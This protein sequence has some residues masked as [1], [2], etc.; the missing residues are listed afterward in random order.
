MTKYIAYYRV[1]T[2]KQGE[3][4][5]GLAAQR[6]AV[7]RYVSVACGEIIREFTEIESGKRSDRPKLAEALALTKRSGG[8]LVVAK[9][10]RLARNVNFL[11]SL[12]NAGV[13]FVCCDNPTANKL[14][15]QILA[16]MAEHEREM[17]SKRTKEGLAAAK[18]R[19]VILGS[20]REGHWDGLEDRRR[21]G[22]AKGGLEAGKRHK[23]DAAHAY[24][25]ILPVMAQ[26]R[27]CG[28]TLQGIA[29]HLNGEGYKTRRN[30]DWS[31]STVRNVL[32]Q[33]EVKA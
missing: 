13:D 15:I 33:C 3:S 23:A 7:E 8:V 14:T 11:T 6:E 19:G 16:V 18:A 25:D 30:R 24:D 32:K 28:E 10:D 4:G 2:R 31:P 29:D 17:I 20:R 21:A 27:A 26:M 5:L 1:S 22:A 9:L 12:Q